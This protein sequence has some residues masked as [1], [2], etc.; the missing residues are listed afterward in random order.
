MLISSVSSLHVSPL[1]MLCFFLFTLVPLC[2]LL[3]VTLMF[4][5]LLPNSCCEGYNGLFLE[6]F[7]VRK[8]VQVKFC[9]PNVFVQKAFIAVTF[10][11]SSLHSSLHPFTLCHTDPFQPQFVMVI[12]PLVPL[13]VFGTWE[14]MQD[15]GSCSD[16]L[17]FTLKRGCHD[18]LIWR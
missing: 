9:V 15:A 14:K 4:Y 5:H 11:P 13:L 6:G 18:L 8:G 10:I 3:Q 1:F 2:F 16:K 7:W 12:A 17:Y